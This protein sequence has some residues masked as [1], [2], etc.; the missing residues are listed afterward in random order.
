MPDILSQV[1][2]DAFLTATG[3]DEVEDVGA[4]SAPS[5]IKAADSRPM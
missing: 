1:E 3:G 2:I 4:G 5:P